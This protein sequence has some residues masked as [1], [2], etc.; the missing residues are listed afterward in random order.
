M[1]VTLVIF[2]A[3]V[4]AAVGAAIVIGTRHKRVGFIIMIIGLIMAGGLS[5]SLLLALQ[6]M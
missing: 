3:F 5:L 4:I 1:P 2:L 6:N